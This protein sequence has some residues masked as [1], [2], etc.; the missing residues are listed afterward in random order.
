MTSSAATPSH[1][2]SRNASLNGFGS[3][4]IAKG[5]K[6]VPTKPSTSMFG[7]ERE[8]GLTKLHARGGKQRQ[9]LVS[10]FGTDKS[11]SLIQNSR[12]NF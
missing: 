9:A 6:Y 1:P 12:S 5:S 8:T 7:G 2:N 3:S 10:P 11:F 4:N